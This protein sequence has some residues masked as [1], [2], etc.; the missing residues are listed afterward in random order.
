MLNFIFQ[1]TQK[2]Y[3]ELHCFVVSVHRSMFGGFT[4]F[5]SFHTATTVSCFIKSAKYKHI[6]V[7]YTMCNCVYDHLRTKFQQQA[8]LH[9]N[10]KDKLN[11]DL[12][13]PI[14]S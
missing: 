5:E 4:R 13:G 11:K 8:T 1:R 9:T 14:I 12:A 10:I 7:S 2:M 3:S 6:Y